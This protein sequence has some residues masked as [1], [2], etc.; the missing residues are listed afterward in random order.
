[1]GIQWRI[2]P[3]AIS[4]FSIWDLFGNEFW[5]QLVLPCWSLHWL[6]CC[7]HLPSGDEVKFVV[8]EYVLESFYERSP[9]L[10]LD[11]ALAPS[12]WAVLSDE[13]VGHDRPLIAM[14][15]IKGN[16]C[17]SEI[18]RQHTFIACRCPS[19]VPREEQHWNS[20]LLAINL[21][22]SISIDGSIYLRRSSA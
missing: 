13:W 2:N 7:N 10:G 19:A 16:G 20:L 9:A 14:A 8:H 3:E 6:A 22:V 18:S 4:Y 11:A 21:S 12:I 1:M 15:E 5:F 17:P